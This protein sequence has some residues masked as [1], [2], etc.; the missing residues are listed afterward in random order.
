MCQHS[1]SILLPLVTA[2]KP[3]NMFPPQH[4]ESRLGLLHRTS[5]SL[6]MSLVFDAVWKACTPST[7]RCCLSMLSLVLSVPA[8]KVSVIVASRPNND[9][10]QAEDLRWWCKIRT[11]WASLANKITMEPPLNQPLNVFATLCY[12]SESN[13]LKVKKFCKKVFPITLPIVPS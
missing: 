2:V 4:I 8:R 6:E 3:I 12:L 10:A 9:F 7:P 1:G 5:P 11:S 13:R